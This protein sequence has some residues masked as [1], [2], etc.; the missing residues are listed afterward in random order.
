MTKLNN[1]KD[2]RG[3][4]VSNFYSLLTY[5]SFS[6]L[7]IIQGC[8]SDSTEPLNNNPGNEQNQSENNVSYYDDLIVFNFPERYTIGQYANGDYWVYNNGDEVTITQITP[9]SENI[10]GRTIN[11]T[12]INP[13]ESSIQGYDSESRDMTYDEGL[14]VDPGNTGIPLVVSPGTSVVKSISMESSKGR[15]IISDAVVLTVVNKIPV[16]GAFRPPY[17]GN[18][19]SVI[20]TID[21]LDFDVLGNHPRLGD[22]PDITEV[23]SYYDRVWLEHC[24]EWTQRDIHP[25]NNMPAYGRD[26]ADKSAIGLILLQL[27]YSN[28]EK[29]ELL[30][31]LVQYGIDLY[32]LVRNGAI[33]YNNGGH[34]L[35]RKMPMLLAAKVLNNT[36]MLAY[37]DKEKY[38]IFQDD[39][40]HFYVSTSEVA[41]T[42]SDAWAP[43][44]RAT[45]IPYRNE[46]IGLAEWG[47]RHSDRPE[48][49]N[50]SW[51]ATYRLV[52][53]YAQTLHIFAA[54]LMG[55]EDDWNWPP[56]FDYTDRFYE[57]EKDK[58]PTYFVNLWEVYR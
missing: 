51:D 26:I 29:K 23:V 25:L 38:F 10:V 37:S 6:I 15:P 9:V 40:Q 44:D 27:D 50:K 1:R 57:I 34:N 14:N 2:V 17:T 11:G 47:I 5:A 8:D 32:G 22:E 41:L 56:V 49:D 33:W 39:Q 7:F 28:A 13:V 43:D 31:N 12:M 19:K 4:V 52:N 16:D 54:R 46:D 35:G 18:D 48:A 21:D 58:F 45:L 53:G 36:D 20:A 24:T 42:N 3:F 30:I 55:V